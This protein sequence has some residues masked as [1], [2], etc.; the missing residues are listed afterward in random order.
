LLFLKNENMDVEE[1]SLLLKAPKFIQ[2]AGA[3]GIVYQWL[4]SHISF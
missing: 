4:S 2:E 3:G 1:M